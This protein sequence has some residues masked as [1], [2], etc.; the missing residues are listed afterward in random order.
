MLE[1]I[2]QIHLHIVCIIVPK[3]RCTILSVQ[4]CVTTC[5]FEGMTVYLCELEIRTPQTPSICLP[6]IHTFILRMKCAE[7]MYLPRWQS[8]LSMTLLHKEH[9]LLH[10]QPR[11]VAMMIS[12]VRTGQSNLVIGYHTVLSESY[13]SNQD[14]HLH[15]FRKDK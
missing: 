9:Y 6:E 12:S 4:K 7:S 5:C 14:A 8:H 2:A 3:V 1:H 13:R 11:R 15:V 10:L